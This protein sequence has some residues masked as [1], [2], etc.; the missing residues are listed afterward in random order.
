MIRSKLATGLLTAAM[1]F[2]TVY[3]AHMAHAVAT[4][5][6]NPARSAHAATE[7]RPCT[8]WEWFL[9]TYF[10]DNICGMPGTGEVLSCYVNEENAIVFA[11]ICF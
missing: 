8:D 4:P 9:A 1:M 2:A 3:P 7:A 5:S 6:A 10:Q 11:G